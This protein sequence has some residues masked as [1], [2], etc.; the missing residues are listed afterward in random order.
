M[1]FSLK[2]KHLAIPYAVYLTILVFIPL[3]FILYSSFTDNSGR[4]TLENIL[5]AFTSQEALSAF[6]YSMYYGGLTTLLCLVIGY[7]IAYILASK[8]FNMPKTVIVLF[9]LPMW[10]NFLIR[11]LAV[12]E[13][14]YVI[15]IP[16]GNLA[17]VIGM[18]YDFLPFMIL[19]IYITLIKI[20]KS[21]L[22]ASADLGANDTQ[23]LWKTVIP[24][25]TPGIVSGSTMVFMPA[26]STYVITDIFSG[27]TLILFGNLI[28]LNYNSNWG[29]SS[30]L[31]MVMLAII[32]I[33]MAVS[34]KFGKDEE[35]MRG[36][37]LW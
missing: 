14:F 27:G 24:L 15:G 34:A 21:L 8:K 6:I 30:A 16:R 37:G 33:S 2:R 25:S 11:S 3:L 32:G 29:Y 1:K 13:I 17:A 10:I 36:G 18:V 4:F 35:G 12:R 9:I 31:A 19:P 5:R 26:I 23:T 20:D 22:E 28:N 7:P